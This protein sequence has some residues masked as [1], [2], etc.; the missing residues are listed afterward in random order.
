LNLEF[1]NA[2]GMPVLQDFESANVPGLFFMGLDRLRNFRS[3]FLRGIREDAP[4][5]ANQLAQRIEQKRSRE[6][7]SRPP[8]CPAPS[9]AG[10]RMAIETTTNRLQR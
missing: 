10:K 6:T 4:L 3:R 5:L 1:E 7:V 9:G 2:T 8:P